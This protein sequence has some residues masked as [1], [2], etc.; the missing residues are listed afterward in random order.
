MEDNYILTNRLYAL[1]VGH[2][3]KDTL[4]SLSFA[5][6]EWFW[7]ILAGHSLFEESARLCHNVPGDQT[8]QFASLTWLAFESD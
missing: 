1:F 2:P 8:N 6:R 7:D 4:G 5:S 3:T